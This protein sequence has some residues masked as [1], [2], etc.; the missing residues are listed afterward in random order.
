MFFSVFFCRT[1]KGSQK[2][3]QK[4]LPGGPQ[5][6][7]RLDGSSF[8]TFAAKPKKGLQNGSQNGAFGEPKSPL[9]YFL[10]DFLRGNFWKGARGAPETH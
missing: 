9:Y 3:S 6:G 10:D 2:D 5:E 8:F 4:G 7:S 1:E